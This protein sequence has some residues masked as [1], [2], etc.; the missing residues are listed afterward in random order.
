MKK[1][2]INRIILIIAL[3][4][5]FIRGNFSSIYEYKL[6]ATHKLKEIK[7]ISD[8]KCGSASATKGYAYSMILKLIV[9]MA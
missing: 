8:L 3:D 6:N 7:E 5:F 9:K 4:S 1:E 2:L